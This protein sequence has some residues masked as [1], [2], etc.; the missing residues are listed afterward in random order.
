MCTLVAKVKLDHY[1]KNIHKLCETI[2]KVQ[3]IHTGGKPSDK[4]S[5]C[6]INHKNWS[7]INKMAIHF[8]KKT[9]ENEYNLLI[10]TCSK[11]NPLLAQNN[12]NH[13]RDFNDVWWE[14]I[15]NNTLTYKQ[16][17]Y[18]GSQIS[19]TKRDNNIGTLLQLR[20]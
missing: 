19:H 3:F 10:L 7:D 18:I 2:I 6:G 15:L 1:L 13:T 14:V 12:W 16:I 20:K 17:L 5:I 8:W 4:G 11:N 9:F